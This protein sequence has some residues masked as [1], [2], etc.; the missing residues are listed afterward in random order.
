MC[1]DLS[2]GTPLHTLHLGSAHDSDDID[3]VDEVDINMQ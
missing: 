3:E 2:D 1:V